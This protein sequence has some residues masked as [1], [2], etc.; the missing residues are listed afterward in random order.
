M[1]N[2]PRGYFNI[3]QAVRWASDIREM[4]LWSRDPT[5][6]DPFGDSKKGFDTARVLRDALECGELRAVGMR[7]EDGVLVTIRAAAWRTL[8]AQ[9]GSVQTDE[10]FDEPKYPDTFGTT[11][12]PFHEAH[13]GRATLVS[14]KWVMPLVAEAD[15]ARWAGEKPPAEPPERPDDWPVPTPARMAPA[16]AA[17]IWVNGYATS[18]ADAGKIVKRDDNAMT[19]GCQAATGCTVDEVREAYKGLPENLRNPS[20]KER[21]AAKERPSG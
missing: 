21:Q 5:D 10:E 11:R 16:E 3:Y 2:P 13:E 9:R 20:P 14:G 4:H 18:A 6:P 12:I 19:R 1:L 8:Y 17:R 7:E 15:L